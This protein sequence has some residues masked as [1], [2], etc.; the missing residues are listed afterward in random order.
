V[1]AH[2][3]HTNQCEELAKC[4]ELALNG[5]LHGK[6]PIDGS[7]R[8]S[9]QQTKCHKSCECGSNES[10]RPLISSSSESSVCDACSEIIRFSCSN[11][12]SSFDNEIIIGGNGDCDEHYSSPSTCSTILRCSSTLSCNGG[13]PYHS[14]SASVAA[15]NE[16]YLTS[17]SSHATFNGF[18]DNRCAIQSLST[19][20]CN[21]LPKCTQNDKNRCSS[22]APSQCCSQCSAHHSY[23]ADIYDGNDD[24]LST[25][26]MANNTLSAINLSDLRSISPSSM[27]DC[28]RHNN[29]GCTHNMNTI[30]KNGC[31]LPDRASLCSQ[32]SHSSGASNSSNSSG[33]HSSGHSCHCN[34]EYSV[35]RRQH[36]P[37]LI[38]DMLY[39]KPKNF[40]HKICN[41][42]TKRE[43]MALCSCH[44]DH[45]DVS[46]RNTITSSHKIIANNPKT[47]ISCENSNHF[48]LLN[49]S[50]R[51]KCQ[52]M[53]EFGEQYYSVPRTALANIYLKELKASQNCLSDNTIKNIE[54]VCGDQYDVP[55]K[56]QVHCHQNTV[57]NNQMD[58][59]L[60]SALR[61]QKVSSISRQNECKS[62]I[63]LPVN[64]SNGSETQGVNK[65]FD[66]NYTIGDRNESECNACV[67][68]SAHTECR[69]LNNC[70]S[71]A[72]QSTSLQN[73][74][75][76]NIEFIQS[77]PLYENIEFI[78]SKELIIDARIKGALKEPLADSKRQNHGLY[79]Y[80][81]M[82]ELNDRNLTKKSIDTSE[83]APIDN[84]MLMRPVMANK[85]R[86]EKS[87][88]RES[89]ENISHNPSNQQMFETINSNKSG[90]SSSTKLSGING[91][92]SEPI[93][94]LKKTLSYRQR[95]NSSD[96]NRD[97]HFCISLPNAMSCPSSPAPPLRSHSLQQS[98][99]YFVVSKL[100]HK[101][102]EKSFSIDDI[103]KT[104]LSQTHN[105]FAK[106][107]HKIDCH[108]SA[109]C[110]KQR[111]DADYR[112]SDEDLCT[113]SQ[114]TVLRASP[115]RRPSRIGTSARIEA[116][117]LT[118][119]S[120]DVFAGKMLSDATL[121][122]ESKPV[123]TVQQHECLKFVDSST[124][125]SDMSDY[126]E[127]LSLSS[128][129]SSG[130]DPTYV[131]CED[132]TQKS[133]PI[134][135]I[136]VESKQVNSVDKKVMDCVTHRQN[137][138]THQILSP[139]YESQHSSAFI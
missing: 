138:R 110:L 18:A 19:V 118:A 60:L 59:S 79:N 70:V 120:C 112:S 108:K 40:Q 10:S 102:K 58:S 113:S 15:D 69:E 121:K 135:P 123:P 77:I 6:R 29:N 139:G 42:M 62:D 119:E 115:Q 73:D 8:M 7:V 27:R 39:D 91:I 98:P 90:K 107:G 16:C 93:D 128:R 38:E 105:H 86:V 50:N 72:K 2:V 80:E 92:Q 100:S 111:L 71:K 4:F 76:V 34:T 44:L 11:G 127:T 88:P 52:Q 30:T 21:T 109:D 84:Y 65:V 36:K 81:I 43:Q 46:N 35:P 24:V 26:M 32:S 68:S 41:I 53:E 96:R 116:R 136:L 1:G 54:N 95:S 23:C 126:I 13:Q 55:R 5:K 25:K 117:G 97:N 134:N 17:H 124:S 85:T 106:F 56:Y 3:L 78:Q 57:A 9:L 82:S 130:S 129:A 101:S 75:Y 89:M 99:Q 22:W 66:K 104:P 94:E 63:Q 137:G 12:S 45:T 28:F 61:V 51:A 83:R 37:P 87:S 31:I 131:R 103:S 67:P 125:S 114:I 49:D 14:P 48:M 33:S 122:T 132:L 133:P 20:D 47:T 64:G 74:N